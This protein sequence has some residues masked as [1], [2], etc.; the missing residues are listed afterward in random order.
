MYA[1]NYVVAGAPKVWYGLRLGLPN[2]SSSPSPDPS[3]TLNATANQVWYGVPLSH[4]GALE[5]A[6]KAG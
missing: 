1:T 5:A 6:W 3:L 2:P 4:M